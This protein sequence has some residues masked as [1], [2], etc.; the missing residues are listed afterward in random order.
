[1][2]GA[3]LEARPLPSLH[4]LLAQ[5]PIRNAGDGAALTCGN[6]SGGRLDN[7]KG[8]L[9]SKESDACRTGSLHKRLWLA[10]E[11]SRHFYLKKS[12]GG[13][14]KAEKAA[15]NPERPLSHLLLPPIIAL[16]SE[17]IRSSVFPLAGHVVRGEAG[18]RV[19]RAEREAEPRPPRGCEGSS[20]GWVY[21]RASDSSHHAFFGRCRPGMGLGSGLGV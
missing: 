14:P 13:S 16:P 15:S 3:R 18:L 10:T 21:P 12:P 20:A 2:G 17:P 11:G 6:R 5:Q 4:P 9:V 19:A 8:H 1:M 7:S